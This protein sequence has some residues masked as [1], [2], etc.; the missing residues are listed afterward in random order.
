MKKIKY[1]GQIIDKDSGRPDLDW[2]SAIKNIPAPEN[3]S[4][5]QS[6]LGLANYYN[7]FG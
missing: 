3:V 1:L 7:V 2:A 4:S 5:L 6:F